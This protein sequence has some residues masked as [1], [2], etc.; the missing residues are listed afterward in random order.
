ME[1]TRTSRF[2]IDA[3]CDNSQDEALNKSQEADFH[4]SIPSQ[5]DK[6]HLHTLIRCCPTGTTQLLDLNLFHYFPYIAY[7][8]L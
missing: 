5:I 7:M 8:F 2:D 3:L 4:A 1:L 6:C